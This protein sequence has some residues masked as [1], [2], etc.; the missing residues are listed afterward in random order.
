MWAFMTSGTYSFLK[1]VEEKRKEIDFYFMKRE[2]NVLSYY[3]SD[4]KKSIFAA[5]RSYHILFHTG[6]LKE[7]GFVVMN[8]IPVT[9][10]N[11]AVFEDRFRN[12]SRKIEK[13]PGFVAFR[14]LKPLKGR[15][16]IV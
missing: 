10:D 5:G 4:K 16:Y 9:D 2:G 14:L 7:S 1:Q 6:Q 8:N 12:R 3:E 11:R 13:M 15:T